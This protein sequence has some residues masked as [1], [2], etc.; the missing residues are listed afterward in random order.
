MTEHINTEVTI[1][2]PPGK[3]L[4]ITV[5]KNQTNMG[6]LYS[7]HVEGVLSS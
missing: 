4:S 3:A 6:L 5:F 1:A 2:D 7:F